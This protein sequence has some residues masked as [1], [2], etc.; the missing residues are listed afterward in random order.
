MLKVFSDTDVCTCPMCMQ[1]VSEE[2]KRFGSK[3][4]KILSKVVEEHQSELY[5]FM[6]QEIEIDFYLFPS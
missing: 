3:H 5:S 4:S 2:Y 6:K 1:P